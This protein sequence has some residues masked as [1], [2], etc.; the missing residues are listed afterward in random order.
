MN[1]LHTFAQRLQQRIPPTK[2][3]KR[4]APLI[5]LFVSFREKPH[6]MLISFHVF[7]HGYDELN[8]SVRL[9]FFDRKQMKL[10]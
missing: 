4:R 5:G 6:V 7:F 1:R 10:C 2:W 8:I 9:A 3:S